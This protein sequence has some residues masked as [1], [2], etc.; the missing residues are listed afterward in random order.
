MFSQLMSSFGRLR[1]APRR[2]RSEAAMDYVIDEEED[3]ESDSVFA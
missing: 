1:L 2:E 3:D